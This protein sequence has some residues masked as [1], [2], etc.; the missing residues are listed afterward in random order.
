M[1]TFYI[2]LLTF[3]LSTPTLAE[4]EIIGR[5]LQFAG[6]QDI[7]RLEAL[8]QENHRLLG[9]IE[10]VEHN[11]AK[12][13]KILSSI[14]PENLKVETGNSRDN[15]ATKN[16]SSDSL[17]DIFDASSSKEGMNKN[18]NASTSPTSP[19]QLYDLALADLKDNKLPEAESKFAE[20]LKNYPTNPLVSNAY[21]WYGESFFKRN[22][23][24]KAA[25]NYLKGYKQAPKGP[26]AS[27]SLLK[28]ALALGSLN[29]NQEACS[30]LSKLEAEFPSRASTSITR[31]K[32]AK[33][34]F[35]CKK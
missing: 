9:R 8:E 26:K 17:N 1:K 3:L 24:D 28:L 12:L 30:I 33:I 6:Y 35:G 27:D 19:K 22:I 5:N 14:K 31:A 34:K 10:V 15:M 18:P 21:F 11:I 23:F 4:D 16:S 7:E 29:K 13:E 32:E 2:F 25:I 20:F